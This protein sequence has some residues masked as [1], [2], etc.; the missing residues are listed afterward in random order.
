MVDITGKVAIVTGSSKEI[1]AGIAERLAADG[2]YVV[3]NYSRS[4]QAAAAVVDRVV[5]A[6]G[7]AFAVKADISKPDEIQAL[8][9]ST[10]EHFGSVLI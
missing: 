10:L 3:V 7:K 8:I 9:D 5:M 1:G 6:G 4:A 2:A